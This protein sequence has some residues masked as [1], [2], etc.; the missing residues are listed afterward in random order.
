MRKEW[1]VDQ[2]GL[3][4]SGDADGGRPDAPGLAGGRAHSADGPVAGD[5]PFTVPDRGAIWMRLALNAS[6]VANLCGVT[7]RQVI[8]WAE[9]EYLPRSPHDRG[10]FT[11]H[12][13]DI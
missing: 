4:D 7:L 8:H 9:Q 6:Q 10:T 2:P 3:G 12:A 11:G 5:F 13:V 1:E